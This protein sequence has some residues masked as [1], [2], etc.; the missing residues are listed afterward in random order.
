MWAVIVQLRRW[1]KQIEADL[2][3]E[4]RIDIADWYRGDMSS[5]R[6]L[7]LLDELS[8]NSGYKREFERDGNWPVWQQMLKHLTNETSLNRAGKYA[9]GDNAYEPTVYI[10]PREQRE[11]IEEVVEE[12]ELKQE[13]QKELHKHWGWTT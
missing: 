2:Q 1:P 6:L 7:V 12:T 8:E 13:A 4:Y 5:R 11:K 10:D 9:G 3:R